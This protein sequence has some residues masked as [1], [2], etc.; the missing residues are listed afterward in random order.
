MRNLTKAA[1]FALICSAQ[2]GFAQQAPVGAQISGSEPGKVAIAQGIK[3]AAVVTAIDKATR[4]V[5][6][7]GSEGRSFDVVAGDAVKNFAQIKVNDEVV[8]EYIRALTLEVKKGG[9]PRERVDSVDAVRAK[10]GA[11][12]AGAVGRQVTIVADVIDVSPANKTITVKG[13][14][15]NIV[16]LE[17]KNPD[18]FKV[19]KKGDQIEANYV[20]AVA[21]SVEPAKKAAK[22]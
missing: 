12:P 5:T 3:A 11:K 7:K 20:E 4:T 2:Q 16:E 14:K 13:P 22:K 15:G 1:L 10:P 6:L 21:L 9:G 19:V 17:V 8:V 18:H